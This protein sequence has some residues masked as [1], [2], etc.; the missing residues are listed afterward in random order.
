MELLV[1]FLA[2][3]SAP[4]QIGKTAGIM[5]MGVAGAALI[6]ALATDVAMA[7]VSACVLDR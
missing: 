5:A 3:T 4:L 1:C 7:D 2:Q 6:T